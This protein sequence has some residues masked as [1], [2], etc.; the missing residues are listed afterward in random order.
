MIEIEK[1]LQFMIEYCE[2]HNIKFTVITNPSEEEI[3]R[4]KKQIQRS[5]DIKSLF[6]K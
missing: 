6:Q 4:I 3:N 2:K 5:E 1:R